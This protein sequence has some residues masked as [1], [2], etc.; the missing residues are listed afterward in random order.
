MSFEILKQPQRKFTYQYIRTNFMQRNKIKSIGLCDARV[1][2]IILLIIE[3]ISLYS[4]IDS[5]SI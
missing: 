5:N 4:I 2:I 1:G 3:Y